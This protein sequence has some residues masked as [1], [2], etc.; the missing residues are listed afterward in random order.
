M[1][2]LIALLLTL[3]CLMSVSISFASTVEVSKSEQGV[4]NSVLYEQ[5]G[6]KLGTLFSVE[7]GP[8]FVVGMT[9]A[10]METLNKKFHFNFNK[11]KEPIAY[12]GQ[13]DQD[14]KILFIALMDKSKKFMLV[15]I[16]PQKD[17]M[18]YESSLVS[19][20]DAIAF[21]KEYCG[22][23]YAEVSYDLMKLADDAVGSY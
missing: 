22:D 17:Y 16:I 21:M 2:R 14:S 1:K 23:D 11:S 4:V 12:V 18:A 3:T 6:R 9:A 13:A 20:K 8:A 7:I 15:S 10:Q 5:F 19:R